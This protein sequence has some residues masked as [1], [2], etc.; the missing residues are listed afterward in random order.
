MPVP[1][2]NR[3]RRSRPRSRLLP[4]E[5]QGGGQTRLSQPPVGVDRPPPQARAHGHPPL[6]RAERPQ[7]PSKVQRHPLPARAVGRPPQ[8]EARPKQP[9]EVPPTVRWV[10]QEQVMVPEPTGTKCTCMRP[11]MGSLS[12]QCLRIQLGQR[13]RG[14]RPLVTSMAEWPEKN[15]PCVTSPLGP[16]GPT[17]RESTQRP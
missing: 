14:E 10:K 6:A 13:K 11:K 1:V 5:P 3:F 17:S 9:R 7:H 12:P 16:Y 4:R 8:T 15:H 2:V